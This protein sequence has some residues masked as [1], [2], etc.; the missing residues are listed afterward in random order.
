[1]KKKVLKQ[2]IN[3]LKILV[4][5][6]KRAA[7]LISL[8][9]GLS[10]DYI[11]N[12][13]NGNSKNPRMNSLKLLASS[14]K[15]DISEF[16]DEETAILLKDIEKR[17]L[18][19]SRKKL[20]MTELLVSLYKEQYGTESFGQIIR[21]AHYYTKIIRLIKN[22]NRWRTARKL[23]L[24]PL[25]TR[26]R[27]VG[28]NASVDTIKGKRKLVF[29]DSSGVWR[30][31]IN[32]RKT[33]TL[34]IARVHLNNKDVTEYAIGNEESLIMLETLLKT[35]QTRLITK[36][37]TKGIYKCN[38]GGFSNTICFLRWNLKEEDVKH[39]RIHPQYQE[40][41]DDIDGFFAN[42]DLWTRYGGSGTRKILLTGP[43][44]TGKT[45]IIKS[46]FSEYR[47]KYA[48]ILADDSKGRVFVS[49]A[50]NVTENKRKS[51][52]FCEE[53]DLLKKGHTNSDILNFLDGVNMPTNS[54]GT[55]F[56]FTTNYPRNIDPRI[57]KRPGRI[58]SV[59]RVPAF[60]TKAAGKAG[61]LYLPS[62]VDLNTIEL[63]RVLDR[64]TAAEIK[65]IVL[66][67]VK[68]AITHKKKL[69]LEL[70]SSI[71]KFYKEKLNENHD[72]FD[73]DDP[74]QR[75]EYFKKLGNE[76]LIEDL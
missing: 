47:N 76:L 5:A 31:E 4:K 17:K 8:D 43:P 10:R 20:K 2:L 23:K 51:I 30:L 33:L 45:T 59:F 41:K 35:G 74:K 39:Y 67:S 29:Q 24:I 28:V 44:G 53:V 60:R 68:Y 66:T 52:V 57:L 11:R 27:H 34:F 38:I 32:N 54:S 73:E 61:K 75:E 36:C 72:D 50:K 26:I 12:I 16:F 37:P 1:M 65:E 13:L 49:A 3:N 64:T 69:T 48:C 70:I 62:D 56:I 25:D 40:I 21:D 46:L 15:K 55:Y 19:Q 71:R 18:Q 6:D 7:S 63:G 42:I 9:A 14:F 22:K 58:D